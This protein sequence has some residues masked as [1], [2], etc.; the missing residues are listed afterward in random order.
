MSAPST[1]ET[2][3]FSAVAPRE[4]TAQTISSLVQVDLAGL[5]HRG[6]VR[7]NN[8]DTFFVARF[9]RAMQAL[10][11]NLVPGDFPASSAETS[12]G[13][14]V[15]DG[16][17]GH[18]AGEVASRT[19]VQVLLDLVLQT[20]D[21]IMRV[22]DLW[23]E[24][25]FRRTA[26]RIQLI[27]N[28]LAAKARAEPRLSGM[29]TT[30]TMACSLGADLMLAHVGDTRAYLLHDGQL[31]QLTHD[32]TVAQAMVDLGALTPEEAST[33]RLR[34][35]LTGALSADG[36]KAPVEFRRFKL[37][38]GDQVLLCSDGLTEMVPEP[39]IVETLQ[40]PCSAESCSQTLV[41]LAL[42]AGGKDNVTVVL[43]RYRFPDDSAS[44]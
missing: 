15:A 9:D 35:V 16:M 37:A 34:H 28:A 4:A 20:P 43:A 10:A 14:L 1:I 6:H 5:S 32:Q 33:H 19:A 13:M 25:A 2:A 26:Q 36:K 11:T 24:E 38:D 18:A 21:W 12:Y 8:E 31:R 23:V 40:K 7:P 29:G 22:D 42:E 3:E 44:Q 30:L 17:G 41:D 27:Q 39:K